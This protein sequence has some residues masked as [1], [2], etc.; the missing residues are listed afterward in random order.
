VH[1]LTLTSKRD[2]LATRPEPDNFAAYESIAWYWQ[3]FVSN[4][5][6]NKQGSNFD[7]NQINNVSEH[8]GRKWLRRSDKSTSLLN[9]RHLRWTL[10]TA[11]VNVSSAHDYTPH[12]QSSL[13]TQTSQLIGLFTLKTGKM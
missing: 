6:H 10:S 1:D 11:K 8:E 7:E 9:T 4:E 13:Y 2:T 5:K 12:S 3:T